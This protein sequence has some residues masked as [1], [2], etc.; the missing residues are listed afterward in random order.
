MPKAKFEDEVFVITRQLEIIEYIYPGRSLYML[1]KG[2][3]AKMQIKLPC[4]YPAYD[5]GDVTQ[6][7]IDKEQ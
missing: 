3:K 7:I 5:K 1:P 2:V 6:M 4:L